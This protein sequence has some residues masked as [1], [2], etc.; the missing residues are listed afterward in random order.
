[1]CLCAASIDINVWLQ[2]QVINIDNRCP[3]HALSC[4][5]E[6]YNPPI[7][8]YAEVIIS[9]CGSLQVINI[10]NR[11][12]MAC[13][14]IAV[15]ICPLMCICGPQ[16]LP[17]PPS[18]AGGG[19]NTAHSSL[20]DRDRAYYK[21]LNI[22]IVGSLDPF[23]RNLTLAKLL[24]NHHDETESSECQLVLINTWLGIAVS[25]CV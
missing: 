18:V 7:Q 14:L 11:C 1:M 22:R 15:S 5:A 6:V 13:V 19:S 4:A 9:M 2:L 12:E 25:R 20:S 16:H 23:L 21:L 3:S 17:P 10:D 24:T 8:I